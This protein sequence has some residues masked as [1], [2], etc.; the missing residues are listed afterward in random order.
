[1]MAVRRRPPDDPGPSYGALPPE[2]GDHVNRVWRDA[3]LFGAWCA[4]HLPGVSAPTFNPE[5]NPPRWDTRFRWAR[6]EWAA[7]NLPPT[8][9]RWPRGGHDQLM[10]DLGSPRVRSLDRYAA[11]Q[12]HDR[13]AAMAERAAAAAREAAETGQTGPGPAQ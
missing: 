9:G 8:P 1:M 5:F 12:G 10:D 2:L 13:P 6:L 11:H 4:L 7:E 3:G